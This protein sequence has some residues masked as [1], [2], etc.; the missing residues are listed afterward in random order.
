MPTSLDSFRPVVHTDE[1]PAEESLDGEHFGGSWQ[2]LTPH[3]RAA[4][5]KLG[6]VLN[7]MPPGR[8]GCPLHTHQLEDEVFYILEGT[9]TL[10]YG[11]ELYPLR[12]GSCVSC[13]AGT[14]VAHQLANTGTVDL[15]YLAAGP[16]EPNEVCTYPESGKVMVRSLR[17][18]GRLE[19]TT[20]MDGEPA[21]PGVFAL[22]E[23]VDPRES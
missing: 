4:G 23:A 13:P 22:Q 9:G 10:R 14:G 18:V 19:R 21:R 6:L 15:V 5:G 16:Y 12:P 20:Y 7:R 11:E 1:L 8:V 17:A 3:M 2:V